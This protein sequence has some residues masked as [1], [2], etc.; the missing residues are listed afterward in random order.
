MGNESF[1]S[2]QNDY[3]GNKFEKFM[4]AKLLNLRKLMCYLIEKLF[5]SCPKYILQKRDRV[6]TYRPNIDNLIGEERIHI[7]NK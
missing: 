5:I 7:K 6:C 2:P 3:K 4:L 1:R